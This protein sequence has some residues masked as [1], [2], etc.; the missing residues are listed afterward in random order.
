MQIMLFKLLRLHVLTISYLLAIMWLFQIRDCVE[1]ALKQLSTGTFFY[2]PTSVCHAEDNNVSARL[3]AQN[4]GFMQ[5]NHSV[6]CILCHS[7]QQCSRLPLRLEERGLFFHTVSHWSLFSVAN[8]FLNN[9]SC[10]SWFC[11]N[12]INLQFHTAEIL[13]FHFQLHFIVFIFLTVSNF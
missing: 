12:W 3:A 4:T 8:L 13:V 11:R 9:L 6:R 7:A 10:T 2:K 1:N 5:E